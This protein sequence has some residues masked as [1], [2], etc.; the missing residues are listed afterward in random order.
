MT[1]IYQT[2]SLQWENIT[3][4]VRY[5]PDWSPAYRDVYGYLLAHLEIESVDPAKAPLPMTE[6][7]YRSWFG[8]PADVDA[9]GGPVAFVRAW[10]DHDARSPAWRASQA[11][12]RQLTLF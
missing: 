2:L 3:I 9:E 1:A 12:R 10:L 5:D 7:G 4:E 8:A 6:T 11:E